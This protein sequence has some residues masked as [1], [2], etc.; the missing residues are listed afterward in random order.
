[1][2]RIV[3]ALRTVAGRLPFVILGA[4]LGVVVYFAIEGRALDE[5]NECQELA[6]EAVEP[7]AYLRDAVKRA[8]VRDVRDHV[9]QFRI[10]YER[11]H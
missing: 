8:G 5:A 10:A 2:T 11:C 7:F 6:V 3:L 9:D 4:G 1:M